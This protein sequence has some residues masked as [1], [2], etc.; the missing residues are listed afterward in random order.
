MIG[1]SLIAQVQ[2]PKPVPEFRAVHLIAAPMTSR[3]TKADPSMAAIDLM[4]HKAKT[5]C[6][7]STMPFLGMGA[8]QCL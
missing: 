8:Q 2:L 5:P 7:V 3:Q 6:S 1:I 4:G